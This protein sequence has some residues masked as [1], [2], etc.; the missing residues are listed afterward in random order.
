MESYVPQKFLDQ[1]ASAAEG[2][3]GLTSEPF[4]VFL[5]EAALEHSGPRHPSP[6][7]AQEVE[8]AGHVGAYPFPYR[9]YAP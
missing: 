2:R 7:E 3:L 9:P 5:L 8:E 1:L 4:E 6:S